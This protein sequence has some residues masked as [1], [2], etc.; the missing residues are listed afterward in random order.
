MSAFLAQPEQ[1]VRRLDAAQ[2]RAAVE[3]ANVP[4]LL[5]VL[6]QLTGDLRWLQEPYRPSRNPG[7][8]DNP[9]GGFGEELQAEIRQAALEAIERWRNGEPAVLPAPSPELLAEMLSISMGEPVPPE[10]GPMIAAELGVDAPGPPARAVTADGAATHARTSAPAGFEALIIGAGISGIAAAIPAVGS[11]RRARSIP[12]RLRRATGRTTSPVA[13]RSS[14][15]CAPSPPTRAS[16][17]TSAS[18]RR[19]RAR[20]TSSPSSAGAS[21]SSVPTG[22]S[23]CL[24]PTS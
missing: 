15:T 16:T 22:P 3:Q 12:T 24:S 6:I 20:G 8:G 10:Y 17:A 19:S 23:R 9:T 21:T 11:T 1:G 18:D 13:T 14:N 2:L 7:L 4:V 5:L